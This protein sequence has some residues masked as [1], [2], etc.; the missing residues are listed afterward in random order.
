MSEPI[1]KDSVIS[2]FKLAFG[3]MI[4]DPG[5]K[6]GVIT[7]VSNGVSI[8][9]EHGEDHD[10]TQ[11]AMYINNIYYITPAISAEHYDAFLDFRG[12]QTKGVE[13]FTFKAFAD[14]GKV[15]LFLNLAGRPYIE[16]ING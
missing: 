2:Q 16:S 13:F 14:K 5:L 1:S 9:V 7:D 10:A 15:N 4:K 11:V 6:L 3:M 8:A 12:V